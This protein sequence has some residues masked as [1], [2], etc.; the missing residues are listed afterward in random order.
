MELVIITLGLVVGAVLLLGVNI[1][2]RK[3]AFPDTHVG[4]NKEMKKRNIVCA[5]TMDRMEQK[6]AADEV[7]LKRLQNL[8]LTIE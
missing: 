3:K 4:H 6:K 8:T 5:K 7:K 2:F 1:F